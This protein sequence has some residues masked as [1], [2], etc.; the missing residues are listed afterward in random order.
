MRV[1]VERVISGPCSIGSALAGCDASFWQSCPA[2]GLGK[3]E[4][5]PEL[6]VELELERS[7]AERSLFA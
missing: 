5:L 3:A 6:E 7:A 2:L 4:L 1:L